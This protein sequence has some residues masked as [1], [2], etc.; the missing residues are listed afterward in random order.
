MNK[1]IVQ[2]TLVVLALTA[3]ATSPAMA[4]T[5]DTTFVTAMEASI[6]AVVS[7]IGGALLTAGGV[8][9]AFKW[10]KGALFG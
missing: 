10:G 5:V 2:N 9:V 1:N 7:A 8:A 4:Q 3:L 6:I